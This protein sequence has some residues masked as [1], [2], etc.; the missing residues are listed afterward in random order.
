[1]RSQNVWRRWMMDH[2]MP[3]PGG[4]LPPPQFLAASSRAYEE[5]I[6][7]NEA[8]QIMHIDRYLEEGLKLDYWWMDAGW[9]IQAARLA[10]GRQRGK[11]IPNGFPRGF[12]APSAI[13]RTRKASRFSFGSSRSGSCRAHGCTTTIRR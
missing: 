7:A 6:G 2:S 12:Q 9:Y 11:S 13:T 3:R 1:M 8:N 10:T 5:M 4:K